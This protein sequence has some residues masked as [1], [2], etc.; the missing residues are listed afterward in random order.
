MVLSLL[1]T[2]DIKLTMGGLKKEIFFLLFPLAFIF[3]DDLKHL[4]LNKLLKIYT[5]GIV[6]YILFTLTNAFIRYVQTNNFEVFFYHELVT[7]EVNAIYVSVFVSFTLF[8]LLALPKRTNLEQFFLALTIVYVVLL[9]SKSILFIDFILVIIFYTFYSKVPKSVRLLT[10]FSVLA[11]LVMSLFYVKK[12]RERFLEEYETAFVDNTLNKRNIEKGKVYNVSLKQ[13]WTN[14]TF[15]PN[16]YFPG[17]ALRVFQFRVFIENI[18]E[19]QNLFN[20]FGLEASQ[21]SIQQKAKKYNLYQGYGDFNFHNQYIQ[22][23][24]ELGLIGFLLLIGMLMINLKSAIQSKNFMHI[25]FAFT[26]IFLFLTESFF[27]RQ[28][29]IVFFITLYCVFHVLTQNKKEKILE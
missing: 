16:Q 7:I 8:Y 27:C 14:K 29:G 5:Y 28:R 17:T 12:I 15:A 26:M 23:F 13:A 18:K 25:V 21:S 22:T 3:V 9:S 11:F 20:G 24:S 10:V 19:E 1:W 4:N 2:V 6:I